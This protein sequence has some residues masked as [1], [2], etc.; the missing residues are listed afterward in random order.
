MA[1]ADG[2]SSSYEAKNIILA[3][4]SEVTP[5]P[6]VPVDNAGGIIVDSTGALEIKA[7]PKKVNVIGSVFIV[8][9]QKHRLVLMHACFPLSL[10]FTP[11][12]FRIFHSMPT[13]DGG[14]WRRGH[15]PGNGVGVEPPG[16]RG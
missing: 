3:T 13:T 14:D 6:P 12:R 9:T 7:V 4:G 8:S 2:A 11:A 10:H 1:G 15:W 5:L 16:V